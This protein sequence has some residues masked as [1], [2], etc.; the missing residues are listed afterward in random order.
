MS[1]Y[2]RFL[3]NEKIRRMTVLLTVIIVL[4][5][6]KSMITTVLLTFIFTYLMIHLVQIIQR[7]IRVPTGV[8]TIF[9]YALIVYLIYLAF[10]IYVPILIHQTFDMIKSVINFYEHQ[11][12]DADPVLL[13]IHNY[14][15]RNDFLEQLQNGATIALGYLQDIGKL[16]VAFAVSFILSFFF[17]IEKKK[18]VVFSRL[19]LKGEFAWFFQDIYYFADKFVNTFGLVLEA[20]FI[21]ALL[22]TLLTTVALAAFGFHQL[23]SLAIMIFILS[24]VP[25]AGVIVSCIP[26]SFIAYSQGGIKDV[27]YILF[28]ILLVHLI[29]SYVLNPKLM[30]SKTELPIFYTFI[31]LLI[32]ER[33]LGVWGLIVGIPI[34]T[35]FLD[36]LKVKEIPNHLPKE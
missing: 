29:E 28:T 13:Y 3:A 14:I 7:F 1:I 34:F 18:T 17:M 9:V 25:V 8:L 33:F 21:I 26:L 30:S 19:F 35:F 27:V 12:K 16:A 36:V 20:Q 22:N 10:T 32:S 31:V 23:L 2:Q 24:L 15:E 6:V 5:L 4:F 11:P